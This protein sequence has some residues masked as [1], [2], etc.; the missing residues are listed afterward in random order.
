MQ[1]AFRG[2]RQHDRASTSRGGGDDPHGTRSVAAPRCRG[3]SEALV[4]NPPLAFGEG[5]GVSASTWI[6]HGR[7]PPWLE[8]GTS[9]IEDFLQ[10]T[11]IFFRGIPLRRGVPPRGAP[12]ALP[13]EAD[14]GALLQTGSQWAQAVWLPRLMRAHWRY[15][16]P[17]RA[18]RPI[19]QIS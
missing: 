9:I 13:D 3:A 17:V 18:D 4:A 7:V 19:G 14:D 15:W 8:D 12:H 16:A 2:H 10:P 5:M 1:V 11:P 6:Q